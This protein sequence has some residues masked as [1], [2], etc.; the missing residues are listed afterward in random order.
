MKIYK[1]I[2]YALA[3]LIIL[4]G[5][6][7]EE[8]TPKLVKNI[9]VLIILK[10]ELGDQCSEGIEKSCKQMIALVDTLDSLIVKNESTSSNSR[11]I[12]NKWAVSH[13]ATYDR[14]GKLKKKE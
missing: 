12:I 13:R 1:I 3:P 4:Q 9:D 5:C 14:T 10:Y 8:N 7:Q 11:E 6:S 2:F